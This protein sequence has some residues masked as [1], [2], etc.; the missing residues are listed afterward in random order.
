MYFR[1]QS[2][3]VEKTAALSALSCAV[4]AQTFDCRQDG[5]LSWNASWAPKRARVQGPSA[6]CHCF[7][8]DFRRELK[9]RMLR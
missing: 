8:G 4:T 3:D 2:C 1:H 6:N 7:R 5:S 9:E